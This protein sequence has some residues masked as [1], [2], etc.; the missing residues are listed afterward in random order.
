LISTALAMG[1]EKADFPL[2]SVR[3]VGNEVIPE[4]RIIAATGLKIGASI[5]RPEFNEAR[6]RLLATGAFERVAFSYKPS[7][8]DHGFDATF[9]VAETGPLYRYRFEELPAT[10]AALREALGKQEPVFT[11]AIPPTPLVMNRYSSTLAKFLGNGAQVIGEVNS[12]VPGELMIVFRP[13]G[14]RL[15]I[16]EVNFKGNSVLANTDLWPILN[17]VAVGTPYSEALFRQMLDGSIRHA[18][19]A[20]GRIRVAFPKIE[21]AKSTDNDGIDVTLT[22]DEGEAYKLGEVNYTGIDARQATELNKLG[23]WSKGALVDFAE[24]ET[25]LSRIRKSY[26]EDGYLRVETPVIREMHDDSK[27]VDLTVSIQPGARFS[28]GK[29]SI[30]GLDIISEPVIRKLWRL[31]PGDPYKENYADQFLA[32]IQAEGY[33]DNLA[34]TGAEAALN[35][36]AH[37]ADVT[38]TFLGAKAA[39]ERDRK[40]R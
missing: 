15:N 22:I 29:L 34:R 3:I 26:R 38:L 5:T 39:A 4:E 2:D 14:G 27:T 24:I 40:P 21:T 8:G 13:M 25:G 33:F 9:Q 35:E 12:D 16:S 19:E 10:E 28:M 36:A 23:N 20:K 1:Q 30:V 6:D 7:A 11:D 37:T 31:N 17:P 32:M 18:Y